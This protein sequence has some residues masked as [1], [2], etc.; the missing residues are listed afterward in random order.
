MGY[1]PIRL[2][3]LKSDITLGF[4]VYLKLP[5]KIL[6]YIRSDDDIEKERINNLKSKKV[7]KLLINDEEEVNYQGYIDRCLNE[8][9]NDASMSIED[10]SSLVVGAGEATAERILEDPSSKKSYDAAQTTANNLIT[11]MASSDEILKGIFDHKIEEGCDS[12]ETRMQKHALTTSAI[13]ISFAEF[14]K[15]PKEEVEYLGVAGLFHDCAFGQVDEAVQA[16]YFKELKD[17]TP[18]ELTQFK[19]HPKIAAEILSDK[20]FANPEVMA[21]IKNHEERRGGNGFPNKI[22]NF[23]KQSHEVL[24]LCA[25]YDTR[26]TLFAEDRK[27]VLENFVIDQLGNFE[28]DLI[29]KF[30]KFIKKA[31]LN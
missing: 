27:T 18:E 1:L 11:V 26:T 15:L 30:K 21:L 13:C 20:D 14:L 22:S 8:A 28:L 10:K 2:S 12:N 7:R 31:G 24:A 4:D 9:M 3:T 25:Y 19:E 6:L 5:H 29:N 16:L 17:M 23:V